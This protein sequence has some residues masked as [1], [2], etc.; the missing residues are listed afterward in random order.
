MIKQGYYKFMGN[1]VEYWGGQFA[2]DI[3]SGEEIPAD[4]LS[5]VGTYLREEL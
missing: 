2:H 4:V 1:T 5:M 3:D